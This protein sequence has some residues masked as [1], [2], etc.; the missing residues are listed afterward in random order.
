MKFNKLLFPLSKEEFERNVTVRF[1]NINEGFNKFKHIMLQDK[2]EDE[3]IQ[4]ISDSYDCNG[5]E[6]FYIDLYLNKISMENENKFLE[7]L[8]EEDR[9][10]YDQLKVEYSMDTVYY[11]ISKKLVPFIAR[12]N[13]REVL[14]STIYLAKEE[15]TIWGNFGMKFPIFY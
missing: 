8:I 1:N 15:K 5:F 13:T 11:R 12:L 6:N 3:F 7:M 9:V 14:F 10:I 2:T 4:Y